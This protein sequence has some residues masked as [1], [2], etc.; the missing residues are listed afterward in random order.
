MVEIVTEILFRAGLD[1]A[2]DKTIITRKGRKQI[3]T[4]VSVSSGVVKLP[5][6][7]KRR[8]RQE[9][10]Y[11]EKFGI[12][13]HRNRVARGD[14]IYAARLDGKV[15]FWLQ[16]EPENAMAMKGKEILRRGRKTVTV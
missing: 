5:R 1:V 6:A 7:T 2:D 8:L 11:V 15:G 14:P 16:I 10:H 13:E 4:G 9:I 3:V 12:A